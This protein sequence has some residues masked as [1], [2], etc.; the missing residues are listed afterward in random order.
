MKPVVEVVPSN[1]HPDEVV[2]SSDNSS[3]EAEEN[4]DSEDHEAELEHFAKVAFIS[5]GNG[6]DVTSHP[7][8]EVAN[9]GVAESI[10]VKEHN[11]EVIKAVNP[12]SPL[13]NAGDD[14]LYS[15]E[16][17]DPYMRKADDDSGHIV[18]ESQYDDDDDDDEHKSKPTYTNDDKED[19][20]PY[21]GSQYDDYDDYEEDN[22][23]LHRGSHLHDY[24]DD[25]FSNFSD[26][27]KY[28]E[29]NQHRYLE[30]IHAD[31]EYNEDDDY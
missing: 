3:V 19:E 30:D 28:N 24:N 29:S 5:N 10:I 16:S 9:A 18:P 11:Q 4:M 22:P 31:L 15:D 21:E 13:H 2:E 12:P 14:S 7:N 20:E 27:S 23:N 17:A 1:T 8:K 26:E 25:Q 6:H